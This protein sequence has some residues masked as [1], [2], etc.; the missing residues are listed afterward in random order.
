MRF[1]T[2]GL[3]KIQLQMILRPM[4]IRMRKRMAFTLIELLTVIAI[5]GILAAML[6]AGLVSAVNAAKK[7]KARLQEQDL[8]TA[9][10]QYDS[11]YGRFPV[12]SGVQSA[13]TGGD[14]TFGDSLLARYAA[15]MVGT[16]NYT[17]NN[18]EVI[19]MLMDLTNYPDGS[20]ATVNIGHG[21]NPQHTLFLNAKM[22]GDT[23]LPGVG[24]DLIYRDPWGTPYVITMDLSY[25]DECRDVFYS[26]DAVSG[27]N[28]TSANPG[29]NGLVNPDP[30][31]HD[32]FQFHGK[33]MV[34]SAGPDKKID[35]QDSAKDWENRNNV[36][37]WK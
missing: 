19:A 21:K 4:T 20:G 3:G 32:D 37:S 13:A 25:D 29:L 23:N 34:W 2:Y 7:T 14:F 18:S 17:T 36:L 22:S 10:E 33:V 6:M 27:F 28:Q 5:I 9:I 12:S 1:Y 11:A 26:L 31:K 15:R 30:V 24:P 35:P 16:G 8:V